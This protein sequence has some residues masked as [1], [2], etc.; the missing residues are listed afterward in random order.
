MVGGRD[1]KLGNVT[2]TREE[3]GIGTAAVLGWSHD[4]SG[5]TLRLD[6]DGD[7]VARLSI[8]REAAGRSVAVLT[9]ETVPGGGGDDWLV[10]WIVEDPKGQRIPTLV[11]SAP[12]AEV[13]RAKSRFLETA[14]ASIWKAGVSAED[15]GRLLWRW[16]RLLDSERL[17]SLV[18]ELSDLADLL[19]SM[20]PPSFGTGDE[21]AWLG[22]V[23]VE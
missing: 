19:G 16:Y 8:E 1:E 12:E 6:V 23:R 5:E 18:P 17:R 21:S 7:G 3:N 10:P 9:I 20:P 11:P 2:V 4:G 13:Q 22:A 14:T 15:A